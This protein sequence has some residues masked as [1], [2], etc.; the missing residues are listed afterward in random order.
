MA[1]LSVII[2][3]Y[4]EE[5]TIAAVLEKVNAV[6]VDKEIIVVDDNSSDGTE[7]ILK[8]LKLSN[9]QV[10]RNQVNQGKGASLVRGLA[11]AKG[12]FAVIQDAD[13]EYDPQDYLKLLDAQNQTKADLVL[14]ARFINGYKG[15]LTHRLAN[16]FLTAMSNFLFRKNINDCMTCYKLFRPQRVR[17]FNLKSRGFDIEIEIFAKAVINKL[18]I[19][20][21][22][23]SYYPRSYSGGKKIKWQDGVW[24]VLSIIRHK[25]YQIKNGKV[26]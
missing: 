12:D 5:A 26:S 17:D 10:I 8:D 9:L 14:G 21:V 13:L 18:N 4:N 16:V 1:K 20:E 11:L 23:I 25:I 24:A 2:P 3:V 19:T 22:P 6:A 15:L 7:R